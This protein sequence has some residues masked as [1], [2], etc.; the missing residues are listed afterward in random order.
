MILPIQRPSFPDSKVTTRSGRQ[1]EE[2]CDGWFPNLL[3][4]AL[5]LT[6]N[7]HGFPLTYQMRHCD[8]T[9]RSSHR[10]SLLFQGSSGS[11]RTGGLFQ[12]DERCSCGIALHAVGEIVVEEWDEA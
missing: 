11:Q 7:L 5:R 1:L 8:E 6:M 10:S 12:V 2:L 3:D 9:Q 4:C